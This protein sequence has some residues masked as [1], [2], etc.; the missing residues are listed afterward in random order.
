VDNRATINIMP[1]SVME[2]L[3]MEC[4][5]YYETCEIIY[6]IDSRNVPPYGKIKDFYAW[7]SAT[8]HTTTIFT[9]IVVYLSLTYDVVL[10]RDWCSLVEGYIIN[11]GSC[12]MLPNKDVTMIIVP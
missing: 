5:K 3:G 12:K 8:P 10:A 6:A 2:S 7:I 9:I 1:L 4:T 11:D